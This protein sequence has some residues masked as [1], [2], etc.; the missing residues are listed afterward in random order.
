MTLSHTRPI[1]PR[2][3]SFA[4]CRRALK[5]RFQFT[6]FTVFIVLLIMLKKYFSNALNKAP[7][8]HFTA[9]ASIA[10][11]FGLFFAPSLDLPL[12]PL[13]PLDDSKGALK[14]QGPFISP[15]PTFHLSCLSCLQTSCF[16]V[17]DIA[18]CGR[19]C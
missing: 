6:P 11:F 7:W 12:E 17:H 5:L 13:Q 1:V 3:S 18:V 19:F 4:R 9:F 15:S 16:N 14:L 2:V 10:K 8:T